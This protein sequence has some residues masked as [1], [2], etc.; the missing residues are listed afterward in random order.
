M[1]PV[2]NSD[3]IKAIPLSTE[4]RQAR[5][6]KE[7]VDAGVTNLFQSLPPA[8]TKTEE[9]FQ[10]KVLITLEDEQYEILPYSQKRMKV[11]RHY[12][13]GPTDKVLQA[14]VGLNDA[15]AL[16]PTRVEVTRV[17]HDDKENAKRATE[18]LQY[19]RSTHDPYLWEYLERLRAPQQEI[20]ITLPHGYQL[21]RKSER[22]LRKAIAF[23][24]DG[25]TKS[26]LRMLGEMDDATIDPTKT[27]ERNSHDDSWLNK[28][29]HRSV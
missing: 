2:I 27:T 20:T 16:S 21:S 25:K 13:D 29:R 28:L 3:M 9:G 19:E 17:G 22:R 14:A 8:P 26:A 4:P 5:N 11:I 6:S 7:Y 12:A 1:E 24:I 23:W 10:D 18:L 15:R